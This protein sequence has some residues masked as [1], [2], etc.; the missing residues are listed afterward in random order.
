MALSGR[1]GSGQCRS[2]KI[3]GGSFKPPLIRKHRLTK[4]N[5]MID[6]EDTIV[7]IAS[8]RGGALR[9]VVRV[10]G[11][12]AVDLWQQVLES[13]VE[14]HTHKSARYAGTIV[15]KSIGAIDATFLVWPSGRSY[16]G[17]PV[18]ECHVLGAIP[19]L[20]AV[21]RRFVA[22]G[23]RP[24]RPGEFTLRA[25]LAGRL[26]LVQAEAVLAVIDADSD[27]QLKLAL[28]QLAGG[29]TSHLQEARERLLDLLAEIEAGLDFV[30]E[31]L[32]FISDDRL[33]TEMQQIAS[34]I[35]AA[36]KQMTQRQLNN[37]RIRVA[38]IGLPNAGKSSLL[39]RIA[40]YSAAIVSPQPGTTRD[41]L[42]ITTEDEGIALEWIDTAGVESAGTGRPDKDIRQGSDIEAAAQAATAQQAQQADLRLLCLELTRSEL[43][44]WESEQRVQAMEDGKTLIVG[45]K[46]DLANQRQPDWFP[47]GALVTS[48]Q[49]GA[50]MRELR[51]AI[52]ARL[53]L[54]EHSQHGTSQFVTSTAQR[55]TASLASAAEAIAVARQLIG[56][57]C[58][59]LLAAEIR[60]ALDALGEVTGQVYTDD[61][62]DRIFS[63][64]CIGK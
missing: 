37:E 40:G 19:L 32:H 33:A 8:P 64:F 36:Q 43:T 11:K 17:Q 5:F 54:K 27:R 3:T 16:T 53:E 15:E 46:A 47:P 58:E 10:S 62:L 26:D 44:P 42:A 45:T 35:A 59:E 4:K 1:S 24:A 6:L 49:T 21:V 56:Q 22:V 60:I 23:A 51:E 20:E 18:V 31:D 55:C 13:P 41:W 34:V 57:G 28:E 7:A 38:L 52:L 61:I 14:M 9:G 39:N 29:M 12:R 50:G 2:S 25:F 30:E 63:R 48:S